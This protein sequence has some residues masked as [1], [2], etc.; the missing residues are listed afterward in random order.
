MNSPGELADV[1]EKSSEGQLQVTDTAQR[2]LNPAWGLLQSSVAEK[3]LITINF[4]TLFEYLAY[5]EAVA[6][7]LKV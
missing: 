3:K 5:L 1:V 4:V 2:H 7:V 6:A